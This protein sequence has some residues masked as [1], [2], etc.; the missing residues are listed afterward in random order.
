MKI[1]GSSIIN[2]VMVKYNKIDKKGKNT[3]KKS[4][5]IRYK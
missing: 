4:N 5:T 1:I 3:K 2:S